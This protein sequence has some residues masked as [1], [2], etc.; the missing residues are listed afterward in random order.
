MEYL[1]LKILEACNDKSWKAI[2]AFRSGPV[3]SHL[4]FENDLLFCVEA[5][6][7]CCHTIARILE[8]FCYHSSQKVNLSKSK[9]FFFPNVNPNLRHHLCG[10][11]GVSSTSDLG[12]YLGSPSR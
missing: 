8:D 5:S 10:I 4:F 12:K 9:A 6:V 1:S 3:F 2:K 7:S 11:F